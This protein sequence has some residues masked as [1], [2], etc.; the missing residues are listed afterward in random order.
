MGMQDLTRLA[1]SITQKG[2]VAE[3]DAV[4][5]SDG[6]GKWV[7]V[8]SEFIVPAA[9]DGEEMGVVITMTLTS[10]IAPV[11]L[12]YMCAKGMAYALYTACV[13]QLKRLPREGKKYEFEA[14]TLV[15]QS[16]V[17]GDITISL[18]LSVATVEYDEGRP[19]YR[20]VMP[21]VS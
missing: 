9:Y 21:G 17:V 4:A 11:A 18:A 10:D 13:D 16:V 12:T 8:P 19:K 20:Y 5:L 7:P 14:E 1:Y 6:S 3:M 2:L 15:E